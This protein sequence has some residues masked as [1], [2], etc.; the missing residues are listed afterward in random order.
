MKKRILALVFVLVLTFGM[1][2]TAMAA[3]SPEAGDIIYGDEIIDTT[4]DSTPVGPSTS[5]APAPAPSYEPSTDTVVTTGSGQSISEAS[6]YADVAK[7][8]LTTDVA[9]ATLTNVGPQAAACMVAKANDVVGSNA[10]VLTMVDIQVPDGTG[11]ATFTINVAGIMAGQNVTILHLKSADD[12]EVIKPSA[13]NNGSV[14]FTMSSYSPVAVVVNAT[15][16]KTA[17][18]NYAWVAVLALSCLSGAV[19]FSKKYFAK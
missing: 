18:A 15:A 1:S 5:P 9:G 19:F 17:D 13:V 12:I 4:P 7:T 3:P 14:T 16:P 10:T 2:M 11:T 8:T 6:L